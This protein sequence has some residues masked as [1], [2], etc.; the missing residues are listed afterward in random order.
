M[1]IQ[2]GQTKRDTHPKERIYLP[3]SLYMTSSTYFCFAPKVAALYDIFFFRAREN[4][5]N[6]LCSHTFTTLHIDA[7][8]VC[9]ITAK[10]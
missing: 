10:P 8:F 9:E 5:P 6:T 7:L 2:E 4:I 3:I 1:N